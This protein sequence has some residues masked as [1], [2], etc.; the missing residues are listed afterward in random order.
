MHA[1]PIHSPRASAR[2]RSVPLL[3][4]SLA[5]LVAFGCDSELKRGAP[6]P[7]AQP[8]PSNPKAP[9]AASAASI[10]AALAPAAA[11][12]RLGLWVLA[13]GSQRVLEHP[14]RVP[15][16]LATAAEI[17]ATDLFVQV[18]RGGRAWFRSDRADASPFAAAHA[19]TGADPFA[20][21]LE[22]A[23]AAGLRVHA[24][25]NVL[26]LSQHRD[27]P[28]LA[29]L[30]RNAVHVDRRGRSVL[31]YP[32]LEIPP[33][34]G[35]YYKM[36]TPAIWLDPAAPGVRDYLAATFAELVARYP[37]LDGLHLDYIR[38]PDVLPFVPGSRF[39][40]GLDFG[41][42]DTSRAR[43]QQETGLE[44]PA[45]SGDSG[46]TRWDTWRREQVTALVREIRASARAVSPTLDLSAAVWCYAD[47]AYLSMSQDWRGWLADG[48]LDFA[49]PM[50]YTTDDR[51]LREMAESF[52]GLRGHE[53]IWLGLGAW[54]FDE[55][56]ERAVAQRSMATEVGL[57]S[58][59][60]FSY[61]A[62]AESP[63][64]A[65]ALAQIAS[66]EP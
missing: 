59:A 8:E 32:A 27:G 52:T 44:A 47:R 24:W 43:Y 60:L 65:S 26:N 34:D 2:A 5:A 22:R 64:L 66:P 40:V 57:R 28:L 54:L 37:E 6:Q 16:L 9:D 48:L 25:V 31:D 58:Q 62:I 35:A 7:A 63:G 15:A 33:P 61:D 11:E 53:R 13:E 23:H 12:T 14:D 20:A 42:G 55:K 10:D 51:L 4:F 17:G 19:A 45:V 18:Y 1:I 41:Y 39:G 29:A 38:H 46:S 49:V 3:L 30:G 56:P 36:G 21:L 50:A